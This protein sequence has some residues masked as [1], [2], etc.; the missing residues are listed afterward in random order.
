[1]KI[2]MYY[3]FTFKINNYDNR[4]IFIPLFKPILW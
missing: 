2:N 1:M 4:I 3:N